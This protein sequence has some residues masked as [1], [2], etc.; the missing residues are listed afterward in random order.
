[1]NRQNKTQCMSL[2]KNRPK[3]GSKD[4]AATLTGEA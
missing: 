1:M 2:Q 4:F 3:H